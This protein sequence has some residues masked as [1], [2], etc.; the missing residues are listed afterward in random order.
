MTRDERIKLWA[1]INHYVVQC[2]GLPGLVSSTGERLV[3][4]EQAVTDVEAHIEKIVERELS[5]FVAG[6]LA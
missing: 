5:D 2:G 4:R 3:K 1:A 6:V